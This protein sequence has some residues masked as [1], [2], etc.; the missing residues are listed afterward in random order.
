MANGDGLVLDNVLSYLADVDTTLRMLPWAAIR[1][2]IDRLDLARREG[3]TVFTCG[4]GGSA[5]TAIH[6]A[7][8]L[9]KGALA[10]GSRPIRALALCENISLVTAW[11]N[12]TSYDEVFKQRLSPWV[13]AGDVLVAI[14]GSGNSPNVLGAVEL[15]RDRGATC[16]GLAGFA[17]GKLRDLVDICVTVPSNSLE[18]IEDVHLVLCHLITACLRNLDLADAPVLNR[19]REAR[20][21]AE[22]ILS[23]RPEA[24]K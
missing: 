6:F 3:Q 5:A 18:Q 13:R 14:S 11:A 17:G 19:R 16:I 21:L 12:D 24:S 15:A 9:A 8:D 10:P 23:E 2:V 1:K 7:C 4:N 20:Q 22:E